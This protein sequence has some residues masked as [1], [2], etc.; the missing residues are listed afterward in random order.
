MLV[1]YNFASGGKKNDQ[2]T[3]GPEHLKK[4]SRNPEYLQK[5]SVV[6]GKRGTSVHN[7]TIQSLT[8]S[9]KYWKRGAMSIFPYQLHF[10]EN[11]WVSQVSIFNVTS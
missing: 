10:S 9:T 8:N 2:H 5:Q 4:T 1:V 6:N 11:V 3:E 7:A